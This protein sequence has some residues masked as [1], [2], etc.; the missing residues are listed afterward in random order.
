MARDPR[1][2]RPNTLV[3]VTNTTFQNRFLTRP[4]EDLNDIFL[5]VLG[6]AQHK[7]AMPICGVVVLSSHYH[8]L[9]V[10]KDPEHLADFMEFLNTNLSKEIGRLHSWKGKLWHDRYHLVPVSNEEEAQIRRLRYL[11]AAGVKEFLVDR[12][13]KWPGVHSATALIEGKA[14]VGHWYNRT[15]EYADH[16]RGEKNPDPKKHASEQRVFFSPLP[17]W[18]HLSG[19]AWCRSVGELVADIDEEGA[20]ERLR[21]GRKS[22]GVKRILAAKPTHR[23]GTVKKSPRPRYH[24]VTALAFKR[25]REALGTVIKEF[26]AASTLLRGGNRDAEFPEGTFPPGLPFVPFAKNLLVQARG[27]PA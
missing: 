20:R 21:A 25:W 26:I 12:V 11:L 1:Y 4:S 18:E 2:F 15:K 27:Q 17:C 23:P 8:L 13:A 9:L 6:L 14:L 10:P 3:E 7:H 5:G 24:A 16:Q 22:L 19:E